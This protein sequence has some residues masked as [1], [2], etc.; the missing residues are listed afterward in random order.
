MKKRYE[1]PSMKVYKLQR[2][3]HLLVGS[4][5]GDELNYAPGIGDDM[6]KLA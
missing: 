2:R 6:N 5:Y 4:G 1:K 3:Y